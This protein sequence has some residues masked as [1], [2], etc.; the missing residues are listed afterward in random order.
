M[1]TSGELTAFTRM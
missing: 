1:K